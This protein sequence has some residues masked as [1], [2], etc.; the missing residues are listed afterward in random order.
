M[1][2]YSLRLPWLNLQISWDLPESILDPCLVVKENGCSVPSYN[3]SLALLPL[4]ID[5]LLVPN[6]RVSADSRD[7]LG[8]FSPQPQA[9]GF[10]Q[11]YGVQHLIIRPSLA[12]DKFL[13]EFQDLFDLVAW[14]HDLAVI[15]YLRRRDKF[16]CVLIFDELQLDFDLKVSP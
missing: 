9:P 16:G 3:D 2:L 5:D 10:D 8:K 1:S 4:I 12:L 15:L 13:Y 6:Y 11:V 14:R 7:L